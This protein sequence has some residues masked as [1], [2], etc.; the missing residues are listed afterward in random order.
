M[1]SNVFERI[2]IRNMVEAMNVSLYLVSCRYIL[3]VKTNSEN[4]GRLK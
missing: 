2:I 4:F 3:G 1:Q